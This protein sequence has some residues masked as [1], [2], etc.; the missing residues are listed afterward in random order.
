M[1]VILNCIVLIKQS[2]SIRKQRVLSLPHLSPKMAYNAQTW[3][4]IFFFFENT[5]MNGIFF[6]EIF[7]CLTIRLCLSEKFAPVQC[8]SKAYILLMSGGS[9]TS[10]LE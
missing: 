10:G 6:C 5:H 4:A 7:F 3:Q 9:G 1:A 8:T 2:C